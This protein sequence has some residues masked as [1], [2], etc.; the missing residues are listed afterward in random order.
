M[1]Q[2]E[3]AWRDVPVTGRCAS[4]A[5]GD[6]LWIKASPEDFLVDEVLGFEP[7]GAGEHAFLQ[8]RKTDANTAWLAK[9]I[10]EMAGVRAR[11]V[12][13]CGR[14]DRHA[15]TTQWFSCWLP[16]EDRDL[17]DIGQLEGIEL[18]RVS[19]HTSKL[20][21]G[22]HLANRFVVRA[23]GPAAAHPELE[24]RV[25]NLGAGFPNYFGSQ[26]FGLG[27]AN[28]DRAIAFFAH[29]DR[30]AARRRERSRDLWYSAARAFLFNQLLD[31]AVAGGTWQ[32][33]TGLLVGDAPLPADA[34]ATL[35]PFTELIAGL[36]ADRIQP[37]QRANCIVPA[38]LRA[39][40]A[41][42]ALV[43]SFELP[44]GAYATVLLRELGLVADASE[45]SGADGL[46]VAS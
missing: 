5:A 10:A 11:D 40:R 34:A 26:R 14:K 13:Y 9:R 2:A 39:E 19:R 23:T 16:G 38:D 17:S 27:A 45:P 36:A 29:Q 24:S 1:R 6:E 28:L 37:G 20:R 44:P 8:L 18:L 22:D 42:D 4:D 41:G 31:A 30:R 33:G 35:A 3:P 12:G 25:R 46:E 7:S 15:V 32:E 21:P 43:L